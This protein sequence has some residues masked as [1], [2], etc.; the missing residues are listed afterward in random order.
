MNIFKI[1]F[2]YRLWDSRTF[3]LIYEFPSKPY[4]L[5]HCD[6]DGRS[7]SCITSSAGS[8]LDGNEITVI[9]IKNFF[10]S[11]KKNKTVTSC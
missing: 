9:F 7:N 6:I 8:H 2:C 10:Q 3:E 1:T 4:A 11:D 5:L